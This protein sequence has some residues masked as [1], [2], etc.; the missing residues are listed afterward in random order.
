MQLLMCIVLMKAR[1]MAVNIQPTCIAPTQE[2]WCLADLEASE[3]TKATKAIHRHSSPSML[4]V[5]HSLSP[6]HVIHFS[7]LLFPSLPS[8]S[9]VSFLFKADRLRVQLVYY[10]MLCRPWRTIAASTAVLARRSASIGRN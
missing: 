6:D 3:A 4:A 10:T 5:V 8:F 1:N 7:H 9:S 2:L